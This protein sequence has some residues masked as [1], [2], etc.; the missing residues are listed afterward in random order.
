MKAGGTGKDGGLG[1]AI[2]TVAPFPQT[3]MEGWFPRGRA[4]ASCPFHS[5]QPLG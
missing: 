2:H 3:L 4:Q 5:P 1:G